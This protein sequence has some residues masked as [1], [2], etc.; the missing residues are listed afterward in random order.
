MTIRVKLSSKIK[1]NASEY[2]PKIGSTYECTGLIKYLH[3]KQTDK[4]TD[5]NAFHEL[6]KYKELL[7]FNNKIITVQFTNRKYNTFS[8]E[9]LLY[10]NNSIYISLVNILEIKE[11][12]KRNVFK[13]I[14]ED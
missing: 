10:N 14:W 6:L 13:S 4:Y 8:V 9:D 12:N 1:H 7:V 2:Y 5:I 11:T 3:N